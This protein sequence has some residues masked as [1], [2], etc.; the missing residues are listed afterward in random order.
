MTVQTFV[1][2]IT[3]IIKTQLET[4]IQIL[5]CLD[6]SLQLFSFLKKLANFKYSRQDCTQ[7]F[8]EQLT[9]NNTLLISNL[10]K[11]N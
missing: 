1:H 5:V 6:Y 3:F 10:F 11:V 7:L 2:N 9:D 8:N 4:S